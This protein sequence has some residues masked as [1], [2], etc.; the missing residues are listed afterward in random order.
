MYHIQVNQITKQHISLP[1]I[2]AISNLNTDDG[3]IYIYSSPTVYSYSTTG[4]LQPL[5][6]PDLTGEVKDIVYNADAATLLLAVENGILQFSLNSKNSEMKFEA[7][8]IEKIRLSADCNFIMVITNTK[9]FMLTPDFALLNSTPMENIVDAEFSANLQ[10]VTILR[11]N[12]VIFLS[13][14]LHIRHRVDLEESQSLSIRPS[15]EFATVSSGNKVQFIEEN[16]NIYKTFLHDQNCVIQRMQWNS[17]SE[18]LLQIKKRSANKEDE[19]V[20]EVSGYCYGKLVSKYTKT[21]E[22]VLDAFWDEVDPNT[23]HVICTSLD[24]FTFCFVEKKCYSDNEEKNVI[25]QPFSETE[26]S[27]TDLNKGIMPPPLCHG[28]IETTLQ[29]MRVDV[30]K[31]KCLISVIDSENVIQLYLYENGITSLWRK[32]LPVKYPTSFVILDEQNALVVDNC[33]GKLMVCNA[34]GKDGEITQLENA[35]K[36]V[37]VKASDIDWLTKSS[38]FVY[39][40]LKDNRMVRTSFCLDTI[41]IAEDMK[42]D[43]KCEAFE[44]KSVKSHDEL[45]YLKNHKFFHNLTLLAEKVNSFIVRGDYVYYTTLDHRLFASN[46]LNKTIYNRATERGSVIV[47]F[48]EK[49]TKLILQ[50]PRGNLEV[51]HPR[52]VVLDIV[53]SLFARK[54]YAEMFEV[55]RRN[56]VN[57]NFIRNYNTKQIVEDVPL[58]VTP[59]VKSENVNAFLL[60]LEN[61]VLGE[62]YSF[63]LK[64]DTEE[65]TEETR[66]I[67]LAVR[68]YLSEIHYPEAFVKTYLATFLLLQPVDFAEVLVH[69]FNFNEEGKKD[70]IVYLGTFFP[71]NAIFKSALLTKSKKIAKFVISYSSLDPKEYEEQ[72]NALEFE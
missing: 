57:Y 11:K 69:L 56:K 70:G 59:E 8:N 30:I 12:E 51:I 28:K 60:S 9:V 23:F 62:P 21:F 27:I 71:I 16:C 25:V 44:I 1:S 64:E 35:T 50:M 72:I 55:I 2:S 67:A 33:E 48:L 54:G 63:Y 41:E 22:S 68:H 36:N 14:E 15:C 38:D 32:K 6:I 7:K 65:H 53:I 18:L 19:N 29:D 66:Q 17:T 4:V 37:L 34:S 3:V 26:I 49:D 52:G 20:I 46:V 43:G 13:N 58:I 40:K 42:I 5:Q 47:G 45:Y 10:F 39:M 61:G 24:H 31:G